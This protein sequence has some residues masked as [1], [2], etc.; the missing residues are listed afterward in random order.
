MGL[1]L[2]F[3]NESGERFLVKHNVTVED[4]VDI[5][6]ADY[7]M[8]RP[9]FK[10]MYQRVIKKEK[11]GLILIDIGAYGDHYL[12]KPGRSNESENTVHNQ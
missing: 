11:Y 4:C 8:R 10:S 7:K 9:G 2:Y 1:D 3:M 6:L 5:C 12:L